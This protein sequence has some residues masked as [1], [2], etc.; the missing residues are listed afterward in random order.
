MPIHGRQIVGALCLVCGL[1]HW[2]GAE[3]PSKAA[4]KTAAPRVS[5]TAPDINA[6]FSAKIQPL[7]ARYCIE[8]HRGGKPKGDLALDV[9]P[10]RV[11]LEGPEVWQKVFDKLNA[12]EMPPEDRP[13]PTPAERSLLTGW[14]GER[15]AVCNCDGPRDPGRVT[16]RRLNRAE[17]NNTIRDLVGVDFQPAD[18]FPAD[19][20]GYGFDH[21]GDV[22]SMEPVLLEKYLAAAEKIADKA[23]APTVPK[24]LVTLPGKK[25]SQNGA[26]AVIHGTGRILYS[27][28]ELKTKVD[29]PVAGQYLLR[30]NG[31]GQQAGPD[32][33]R[34]AFRIDGKDVRTV[35]VP[36][37]AAA[38]QIYEVEVTVEPGSHGVAVAFVNDYY[39]PNDP[40]PANRDRN[41]VV[42]SL[43]I[44]GPLYSPD[45]LSESY[46][47]II[48]RR[49]TSANQRELLREIL[50]HFAT[51]AFRRPATAGEVERLAQLAES[52]ERDGETFEGAVK[53]AMQAVLVSPNFLFLVELD[54]GAT[55]AAGGVASDVCALN[56]YE[57]ATRLSYFLWS[58]MPD[59]ELFAL[60]SQ[61][62][63]HRADNLKAQTRRMLRDPKS[64]ALVD[65]FAGQWLGL[66]GLKDVHP[67]PTTFPQFDEALR[68]AML[69]ESELFFQAVVAEDRSILDFIDADFTFVNE[70]LAQHYEIE[71]VQGDQFRRVQLKGDERGGILAQAA[72]LTVTS[73]PT[74]TA[75]VKRGKWV[76]ENLLGTPPPPPPPQVPQLA[77]GPAAAQTGTIRQRLELHR[78]K[79]DCASC[80]NRLDPIGFGFEN[81]DAI[82]GW[83]TLDGDTQIDASGKLPSGESFAGPRELKQILKSRQTQVAR[84]LAEKLLTYALGRGLERSDR[85]TV[86]DITAAAAKNGYKF[87]SLV[88]A[89]VASDTFQK[90]RL[91]GAKP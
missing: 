6:E 26:G 59:A 86:D 41:L 3:E 62:T 18:D 87:S 79:A 37:T 43:E 31:Y 75:P 68:S 5:A 66:R 83:R 47:R 45:Q 32:P 29:F 88:D 42:E 25:L 16:I 20:T 91:K 82:G 11:P 51:R 40:N 67:D 9:Y 73:T 81:Y 70:R 64:R 36:S 17:Y 77:E 30:A 78:S 8:C 28:G 1:V 65:N 84:C 19:G 85:C 34:M 4:G 80:H 23:I 50:S 57:L 10:Q 15:F 54:D 89:I 71:G 7:L 53:L 39:Q 35:D 44:T 12:G 55:P 58:S 90:R 24:T 49:P 69:K 56:D 21:I 48:P 52:A 63:L 61:G 46:R 74:R 72:I 13:Q 22:L 38:P 14:I 2:A 60:A 27:D 76:L 33:A